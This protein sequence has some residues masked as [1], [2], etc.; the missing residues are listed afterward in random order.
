MPTREA[1][2][3]GIGHACQV[4]DCAP[5]SSAHPPDVQRGNDV[6]GMHPL[7]KLLDQYRAVLEHAS[8]ACSHG[9][10]DKDLTCQAKDGAHCGRRRVRDAC[11]VGKD[12]GETRKDGHEQA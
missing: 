1:G 2:D 5:V 10:K 4:H 12:D 3:H 9:R 6:A 11:E 7:T 8:G